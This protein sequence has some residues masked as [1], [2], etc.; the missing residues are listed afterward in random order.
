[1]PPQLKDALTTARKAEDALSSAHKE[2]SEETVEGRS[3]DNKVKV[4]LDGSFSLVKVR[5]T[6]GALTPEKIDK[7]EESVSE[8]L[9]AALARTRILVA[10]R[11]GETLR[12]LA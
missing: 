8:A 11:L 12:E 10:R 2:L 7:L 6:P 1:M 9:D 3:E 5:I 4:T